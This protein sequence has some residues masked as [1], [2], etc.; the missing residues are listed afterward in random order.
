MEQRRAKSYRLVVMP[1]TKSKLDAL[2]RIK[3]D[4]VYRGRSRETTEP[5]FKENV[6][7]PVAVVPPPVAK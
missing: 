6:S 5:R 2:L 4:M 1:E 3:F 7:P